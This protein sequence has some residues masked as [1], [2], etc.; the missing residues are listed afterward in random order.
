MDTPITRKEF[1]LAYEKGRPQTINFLLSRGVQEDEAREKAQAAWV[2]GWERRFQL[3]DKK[4]ALSWVNTIALNLYRS[5]IRRDSQQELIYDI[6]V[7][8]KISLSAFDL[9]KKL[10]L[11]RES[12][13][14]ILILRYFWDFD[15]KD[16]AGRYGCTE[17]AM[18]VKLLRA[19]RS[20][21][22]KYVSIPESEILKA[23]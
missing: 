21:R 13:R 2:K 19:R 18:R 17:I 23:G 4:K 8:F 14:E 7:P 3:K 22:A 6:P 16:L 10:K 11:C 5:S 1:S 12:E 20:L 9:E 15:I